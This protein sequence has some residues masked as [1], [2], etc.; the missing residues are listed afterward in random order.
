MAQPQHKQGHIGCLYSL[1]DRLGQEHT[2]R[3]GVQALNIDVPTPGLC[4]I[5]WGSGHI[6]T[7]PRSCLGLR[8][9]LCLHP[10]GSSDSLLEISQ[11]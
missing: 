7:I 3:L 2:H 1:S 8:L 5:L 9:R 10:T 6:S 11:V 4:C